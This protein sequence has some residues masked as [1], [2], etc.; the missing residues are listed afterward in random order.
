MFTGIVQ[1]KGTILS[2]EQTDWFIFKIQST[3][4]LPD[5]KIGSSVTVDG[6]C[7]TVL[8][9][10]SDSFS[11]QLMPETR[12]KTGFLTKQV[13]SIVNLEPALKL[14]GVLD[15]HLV[16]G[17]IDG[18]GIVKQFEKD[19]DWAVLTITPADSK[20]MRYIAQKGSITLNGVSLT[21]SERNDADFGV[22]LIKHTLENTNLSILKPEDL[23]NIE[24]DLLARYI[25][26]L[27]KPN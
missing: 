25:E 24:V 19:G 16:Q 22:S 4:I 18:V 15:G 26:N 2:I 17:H 5:L 7:L 13:G 9:L 11:V 8:E 3:I 6:A 10:F 14:N 27:L 23:V 20:L 12:N 21:V 1:E